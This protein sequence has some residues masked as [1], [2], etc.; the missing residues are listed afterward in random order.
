MHLQG[1]RIELTYLQ[2]FDERYDFLK[3][4]AAE[5]VRFQPFARS[6]LTSGLADQQETFTMRYFVPIA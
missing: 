5:A 6:H 1:R 2:Y 4:V 3:P